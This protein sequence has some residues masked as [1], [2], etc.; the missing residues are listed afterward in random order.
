MYQHMNDNHDLKIGSVLLQ[1][2]DVVTKKCPECKKETEQQIK[3]VFANLHLIWLY[4]G[5]LGYLLV[6]K[7]SKKFSPNKDCFIYECQTCKFSTRIPQAGLKEIKARY[8]WN[9]NFGFRD[10]E[11]IREEVRVIKDK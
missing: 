7:Y 4:F 3:Y 6:S 10:K 9:G 5:L 11:K 1:N 2:L 8:N